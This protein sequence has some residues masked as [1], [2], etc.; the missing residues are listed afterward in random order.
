MQ[1]SRAVREL[2]AAIVL[3]ASADAA[4]EKSKK[5]PLLI[6]NLA[7]KPLPQKTVLTA[8]P[9]AA[10]TTARLQMISIRP[11]RIKDVPL[12]STLIHEFAIY[13]HADYEAAVTEEDIARDGFG[14]SPRFRAV[15]AESE[16]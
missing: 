12:L 3:F 13:D 5:Q 4:A 7:R 15:I 1:L 2:L 16:G 11:A 6:F 14:P 10:Y 8:T 9:P